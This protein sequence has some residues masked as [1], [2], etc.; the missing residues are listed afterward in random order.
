M[1]KVLLVFLVAA[2]LICALVVNYHYWSATE[3][4]ELRELPPFL[5][6]SLIVYIGVQLLKR[7]IYKQI[8]WYD[9]FYYIGL[10]AVVLP[11]ISFFSS[12]E[13]L[14][15]VTKYGALFFLLPPAVGIIKVF[16]KSQ[17]DKLKAEDEN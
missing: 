2:L 12:G 15:S 6:T 10:I 1:K 4:V 17:S 8:E 7:Y 13:W 14:F 5:L 16:T 9:W 11:L 3:I